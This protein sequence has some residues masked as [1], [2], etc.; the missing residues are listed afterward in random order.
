MINF[1]IGLGFDVHKFSKKNK[2]LILGG[3]KITNRGGLEAVSDGDVVLH[4]ITDAICGACNLGDIG[5]YFPPSK[6]FI[7]LDSKRIVEFILKKIDKEFKIINIDVIIITD[8]PKLAPFKEKILHSLK[9]IFQINQI[10]LKIK[11]KESLNIL[12]SKNSIS[13]L[14]NCLVKV[15]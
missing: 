13:C 4:A 8:K 2:P 14:A 7:D 15:C 12:G 11:S 10:N 6:K 9:K 1:T 3:E 5:D